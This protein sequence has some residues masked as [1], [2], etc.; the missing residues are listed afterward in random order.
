VFR[1]YPV[2]PKN[3]AFTL[4]LAENIPDIQLYCAEFDTLQQQVPVETIVYKEHPLN[5]HYRGHED[6]REWMFTV[7]GYFPSFFKF[8]KRCKKEL[9]S[10]G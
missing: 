8:W 10:L 5:R 9:A 1:Q 3:I 2:A 4:K 7:E 6:P